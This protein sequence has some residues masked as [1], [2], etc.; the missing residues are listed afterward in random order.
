MSKVTTLPIGSETSMNALTVG[1]ELIQR[2]EITALDGFLESC[3][4]F[5]REET[6]NVAVL[7]R[8]KAGKSS[9][10]NHLLGMDFLTVG[11]I[12]VT[13]VVT[14]IEYGPE[15]RAEVV[16]KDA[17]IEPILLADIREFISESENPEN[18]KQVLRVRVKLPAMARYRGIRFVDTPGLESVL[19]HSTEAS[20]N[21]LPSVGLAIVAVGVDPPLSQRD[22]ELIRDLHR[23]TPNV[24]ILLTKVDV[25]N[26]ADRAEV[27]EFVRQQLVR[28]WNQPA[29][30]FP[31]ST[32]PGFEHLRGGIEEKLMLPT[33]AE[34]GQ[35]RAAIL[36][37]KVGS[38]LGECAEYLNVA[39]KAA[40]ADD[41]ERARLRDSIL[42]DK[43]SI[44][45]TRH[46]LRLI[47][48]D[49]AASSRAT[50]E[51]ILKNDELGVRRKLLMELEREFPSWTRNLAAAA[52]QFDL[53]LRASMTREMAVLSDLHK[54]QFIEPIGRVSRQLTQSLQDFRNRLSER[55]LEQLGVPMRTSEMGLSF[56]DPRSPDVRVGK[57]FDRNW[58][59]LSF[60]LPMSLLKGQLKRHFERKAADVVFM[61]LSRLASQWEE[62][63]NASVSMIEKEAIHRLDGLIS[64]IEKL[65][66]LAGGETVRIRADL[67]HLA[68]MRV[69]LSEDVVSHPS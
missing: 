65:T 68:E 59:L 33:R 52:E 23:F 12:P 48:R 58:E 55:A 40:E 32:R 6:L 25:L 54:V 36:N 14:E 5:A 37:H 63:V 62:V 50:F 13:T 66:A 38:L 61:N 4:A 27:M 2:Y 60:L 17:R 7:G 39:L 46:A 45:D 11:A 49:A 29:P 51:N 15:M 41:S 28:Y 30:V 64:T 47:A 1:T 34:A 57:I 42:G 19:Q 8:F 69:S 3:Q 35:Q 16:F 22:L 18:S 26:E 24:S 20:L 10:L 31:Y 44:D 21:W 67:G 53:W 43:I 56:E 9:F